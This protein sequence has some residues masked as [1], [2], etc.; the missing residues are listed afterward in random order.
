MGQVDELIAPLLDICKR[1][2]FEL[3]N[4]SEHSMAVTVCFADYSRHLSFHFVYDQRDHSASCDV[5]VEELLNDEGWLAWRIG[6]LKMSSDFLFGNLGTSTD[7]RTYCYWCEKEIWSDLVSERCAW[8]K[9][10]RRR[11]VHNFI[12]H[13]YSRFDQWVEWA[14][15]RITQQA[16]ET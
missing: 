16:S 14:M 8:T 13:L 5:S 15:E 11:F 4:V 3:S 2:N 10:R 7:F 12:A 1:R 9:S 6:Q